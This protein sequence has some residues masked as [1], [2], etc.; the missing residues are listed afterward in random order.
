M[1]RFL[2]YEDVRETRKY[3][4]EAQDYDAAVS[5]WELTQEAG[6]EGSFVAASTISYEVQRLD[7]VG[8]TVETYPAVQVE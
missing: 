4:V 1:P 2:I 8:N 5:A 7:E 3:L 6:D